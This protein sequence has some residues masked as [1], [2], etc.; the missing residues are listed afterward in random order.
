MN[1]LNGGHD[2]MTATDFFDDDLR[3]GLGSARREQSK[4]GADESHG[5][6]VADPGGNRMVRHKEEL[7]SQVAHAME[8]LERLRTRQQNLERQKQQ[9][10]ELRSAEQDYD[11][12]K[13]ELVTHLNKS[14]VTL[15]KDQ[16][17]AAKLEEML[18]TTRR[19][20]KELQAEL[21]DLDE[22]AWPEDQLRE[23]L[24]KAL[25][26]IEHVRVEYNKGLA[27]I[28]TAMEDVSRGMGTHEPAPFGART[29]T[30]P[31]GWGFGRWFKIGFAF[32]LPILL[33]IALVLLY[34]YLRQAGYLV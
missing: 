5:T 15:E 14:L 19:R 11:T 18:G 25:V 10:E 6:G 28:N 3:K 33:T 13:R 17:E 23:E 34:L 16:L 7:D 21:E 26:R 12:G 4:S 24:D 2:A 30:G 31:A 20:F 9:L 32:S 29:E 8:E 1:I 27:R 22:E